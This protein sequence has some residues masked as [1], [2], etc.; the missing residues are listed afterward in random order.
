M[1]IIKRNGVEE[2]FNIEKIINAITKAT[3]ATKKGFLTK[4]QI[5]EIADYVE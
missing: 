2:E 5:Q 3:D 1:K 4:E